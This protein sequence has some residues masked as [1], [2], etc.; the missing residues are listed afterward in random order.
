MVSGDANAL[1]LIEAVL[2]DPAWQDDLP[3]LVQGA[4]LRQQRGR[5]L[6]TVANVWASIA[7]DKF[8]SKFERDAVS[9]RNNRGPRLPAPVGNR[10]VVQRPRNPFS[11]ATDRGRHTLPSSE[12]CRHP[13][14]V[15]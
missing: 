4:M 15:R 11:A 12:N 13:C 7:L 14:R 9:G 2:D 6:T 3:A 1:R 8:G 10:P 5:W